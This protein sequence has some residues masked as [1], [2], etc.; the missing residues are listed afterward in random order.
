MRALPLA[1]LL[2]AA[3]LSARAE[4]AAVTVEI[5]NAGST[6][7]RCLLMLGHWVTRDLPLLAPGATTA[8]AFDRQ[9]ED[10]A[11]YLLRDDGRRRMMVETLLCGADARWWET[12]A[13]VPLD[14]LR[15]GAGRRLAATCRVEERVR[16]RAAALP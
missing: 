9:A 7:M 4:P 6:A 5:H 12:R 2:L 3:A 15:E 11:L 10:G 8:L 1:G 16:C 14:A 13:P